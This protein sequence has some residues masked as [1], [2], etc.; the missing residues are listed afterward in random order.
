MANV[1]EPFNFSPRIRW[2]YDYYFKGTERNWNNEFLAFST[3]AKDDWLF[4]EMNFYIVPEVYAF[5]NTFN[6][7]FNQNAVTLDLPGDFFRRGL[8]E[9]KACFTRQAMTAGVPVEI[10]PGD[11]IAGGRFNIVCSKCWTPGEKKK[12]H[13]LVLGKGA[14]RER[15]FAF[16]DKGFGNCGPISGHL[17]PD[18]PRILKI[19]FKGLDHYFS[20]LYEQLTAAEK[21]GLPGSNLRAMREACLIPKELAA[22]YSTECMELAGQ[23]ADEERRAELLQ[24]AEN[25]KVVPWEP[26]EDFWQAVQ[27]LWLTHMLVMADE[28]YPGPGVSFGRLDQYLL[29]YWQ[30]SMAEGMTIEFGKE[31]LK[32][33]WIHCNTAYDAMIRTGCNQGITAGYGQLFNLSG[34]GKDGVDLTNELTYVLLEVIDELSPI[35][36]PKP[37]VR[38]HRRSPEELLDR[39]VDMVA[40]SQ[41]APFLLNFDERS[42][43]GLLRQAERAGCQDLINEDNVFDYGCVGCLENTMCGN[44]RSAT[45][46]CNLNLYKAVELAL[47]NGRELQLYTD[48]LWGKPHQPTSDAPQSGESGSFTSFEQFYSAF[49]QQIGYIVKKM[50]ALF[51]EMEAVRAEFSPTPY[52]SALVR[53]CA[54]KGLDVTQGGAELKFITIE[55][56]T[57]ATTVDSLLAIKYLV[58]DQKMCSME[59]LIQALRANWDGYEKLQAAALNRAPKYGRDDDQ[60]DALARRVMDTWT[61][62]TWRYKSTATGAQFRPG[63]LSW[64]Y[65]ISSGFILPASP[66]GRKKGQFLSNAIC[67]VNGAD[68]NGPTANANSVGKAL[69][70]HGSDGD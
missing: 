51:N 61:E 27:S 9:R 47:G 62:E 53:G 8:A 66:D 12:H 25:L 56:V 63:M 29:P 68:I 1:K 21:E 42:I 39:V 38:L 64:N 48:A 11:L 28:N 70:G 14:L 36:E 33:F 69:G 2:L 17:I 15:L 26:A 49:E 22:L 67:P 16:K 3:G 52:L 50:V 43:A 6:K 34:I 54:E 18:Y 37:N 65:W 24:M 32:C 40:A 13:Q 60:A 19:G 10:L 5:F 58:F 30:K 23:E 46:D 31:I 35:L 44:D 45:V 41:G 55:A 57:F 4:E 7:V 20:G 59:E